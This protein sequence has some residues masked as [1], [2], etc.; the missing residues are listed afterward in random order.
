MREFQLRKNAEQSKT[1]GTREQKHTSWDTFCICLCLCGSCASLL[2]PTTFS[3]S[4]IFFSCWCI[5]WFF[6]STTSFRLFRSCS[7]CWYGARASYWGEQEQKQVRKMGTDDG[8]VSQA[9]DLNLQLSARLYFSSKPPRTSWLC[10][11]DSGS[12]MWACPL[13]PDEKRHTQDVTLKKFLIPDIFQAW[14][15]LQRKPQLFKI[16]LQKCFLLLVGLPQIWATILGHVGAGFQP[17]V[18][19]HFLSRRQNWYLSWCERVPRAASPWWCCACLWAPEWLPGG[20][21]SAPPPDTHKRTVVWA[22]GDLPSNVKQQHLAARL[23]SPAPAAALA[24]PPSRRGAPPSGARPR[25]GD[26]CGCSPPRRP[27]RPPAA[28]AA[29]AALARRPFPAPPSPGGVA[30]TVPCCSLRKAATC[31]SKLD[32]AAAA[33]NT[34]D[35]TAHPSLLWGFSSQLTASLDFLL[36]LHSEKSEKRDSSTRPCLHL[37]SH[38]SFRSPSSLCNNCSLRSPNQALP[39]IGFVCLTLVTFR[40]FSPTFLYF[41]C[42]FYTKYHCFYFSAVKH[43]VRSCCGKCE[44]NKL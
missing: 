35:K 40:D 8:S 43:F 25:P 4:V 12:E 32:D 39:R 17:G 7:M 15:Y 36:S 42:L 5:C 9:M 28:A 16:L 41:F 37:R 13:D 33:L 21:L 44:T 19:W 22:L 6:I 3:R 30:P 23:L 14:S 29:P 11:S 27:A 24:A 20:W 34:G 38:L 1:F 31:V 10:P 18:T 2:E 26:T